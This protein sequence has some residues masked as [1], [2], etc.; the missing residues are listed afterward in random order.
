MKTT[1]CK[2]TQD[3]LPFTA[4]AMGYQMLTFRYSWE[5]FFFSCALLPLAAGCSEGNFPVRP[6]KGN[7]VC[8]G[9][10][11]T[12]GSVSFVP[13]GEAGTLET[14][15]AASATIG[16]DG[17][18]VLTTFNRFDGA[19]VGKHRVQYTSSEEDGSD[20][21]GDQV[22]D[23]DSPE[24]A[25]RAKELSRKNQA[26]KNALCEQKGELIVEVKSSGENNFTI[27]LSAPGK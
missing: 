9:R 18:F 13:I 6:A 25:T 21:D 10:P 24:G 3:R 22:K 16:P 26:Q 17:N 20:E 7:V 4:F 11:V 14:G 27:E 8:S 1:L 5:V 15:K 12:I 19:I 23:P 2:A